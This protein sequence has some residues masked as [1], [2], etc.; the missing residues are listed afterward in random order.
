M[1]Q[2]NLPNI[3]PS[4]SVSREEALNLLL[5]SIAMEEIGLSHVINAEGEKLQYV[6]GTLPGLTGPPPT[7]SD[8]LA[9]N[10][11]VRS[12][13]RDIT[14]KE[15][16][17][18][19]KL[20]S[21][22]TLPISVGPTGSAGPTGPAGPVGPTGAAGAT[23][24]TGADGATGPAGPTGSTVALTG[25]Q[26][27][28]QGSSGGTINNNNNVIFDTIINSPGS[29]INY[30]AGTGTFFITEPGNYYISWWVNTDGAQAQTTVVFG[31]RII[32][33]GSGTILASSPFP[34]ITL[35]LNGSALITAAT[36]PTV[37]SLFNNSGANVTYGSSVVQANLTIVQVS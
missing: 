27:Q 35:Q 9:V 36:V 18:Q 37:F 20:D 17:L 5:S 31:I 11:S 16:L 4:I 30:N 10:N 26:V 33:G 32:S 8:L 14:K 21:L 28:L 19:N 13:L 2:A 3:T 7:I 23:G 22:M 1:S 6:L 24:P 34:I 29:G 12:T 15:W 25:M